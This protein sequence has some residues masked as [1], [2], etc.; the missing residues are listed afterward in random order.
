MREKRFLGVGRRLLAIGMAFAVCA[1]IMLLSVTT[2]AA[3]EIPYS[4]AKSYTDEET[5]ITYFDIC[6][7]SA[8][9]R[10]TAEKDV[11]KAAIQYGDTLQNWSKVAYDIIGSNKNNYSP[12]GSDSFSKCW[13]NSNP[14]YFDMVS[15]LCKTDE[16]MIKG[17]RK[18][19]SSYRTGLQVGYSLSDAKDAMYNIP[20]YLRNGDVKAS[21]IQK[22]SDVPILDD[23][24]NRL[25]LYDFVGNL[26]KYGGTHKYHYNVFGLVFYDLEF[27]PIKD[28]DAVYFSTPMEEMLQ[29]TSEEVASCDGFKLATNTSQGI[30]VTTLSNDSGQEMTMEVGNEVTYSQSLSNSFE[31]TSGATYGQE[32]G[33]MIHFG[34]DSSKV[35]GELS[36]GFSFEE[37]YEKA[38]GSAEEN[39]KEETSTSSISYP[40]PAYSTVSVSKNVSEKN[41]SIDY[42]QAV[43]IKYKTAVVAIRGGFYDDNAAVLDVKGYEQ[44]TLSTVFGA[45][46]QNNESNGTTDDSIAALKNRYDTYKKDGNNNIE[47]KAYTLQTKKEAGKSG[48]E[49]LSRALN[50]AEI[51]KQSYGIKSLI[52]NLNNKSHTLS[53]VNAT[54]TGKEIMTEYH[55]SDPVVTNPL[56]SIKVYKDSLLKRAVTTENITVGKDLAFSGYILEG[57]FEDGATQYPDFDATKGYWILT[58]AKGNEIESS[59]IAELV[60]DGGNNQRLK[61]N[62]AGTVYIKYVISEDEEDGYY[63]FD[64]PSA[65]AKQI[66]NSDLKSIPFIRVSIHNNDAETFAASMFSGDNP[67]LIAIIVVVV[68]II[69]AVV[70]VII[71]RKRAA[72]KDTSLK[73]D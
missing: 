27:C 73:G 57:F 66:K 38:Y 53:T 42:K 23:D 31:E 50:W 24:S 56:K 28:E 18:K 59:D 1:Q 33:A 29:S 71:K 63:Y 48:T 61:A 5:G 26:E 11:M 17:S 68:L 51:E 46:N 45:V 9:N 3:K 30:A 67:G 40:V 60:T 62:K 14:T 70:F 55:S 32:I 52:D 58:D 72:A 69:A 41:I 2:A 22:Y 37:M 20:V 7:G 65:S 16:G 15:E 4:Y 36:L 34:N 19:D 54:M 64:A 39:G 13:G 8:Q 12:Y 25:V 35:Q 10:P 21:N 6:N 49:T 43:A 47:K 44:A